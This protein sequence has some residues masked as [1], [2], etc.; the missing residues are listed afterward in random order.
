MP[1]AADNSLS[2]DSGK[3]QSL[4]PRDTGLQDPVLTS[5]EPQPVNFTSTIIRKSYLSRF[6]HF[7]KSSNEVYI[8]TLK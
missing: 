5:S 2:F 3:E 6:L 8:L 7:K 4:S 1:Q